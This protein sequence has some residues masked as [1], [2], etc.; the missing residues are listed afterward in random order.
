[1]NAAQLL[2][3]RRKILI[4]LYIDNI[5][6]KGYK[7]VLFIFHKVENEVHDVNQKEVYGYTGRLGEIKKTDRRSFVGK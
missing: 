2:L 4:A 1:M 7:M 3:P 5:L 6:E